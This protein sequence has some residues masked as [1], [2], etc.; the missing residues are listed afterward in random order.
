MVFLKDILPTG[1]VLLEALSNLRKFSG[2]TF[3][4]KLGGSMMADIKK[5]KSFSADV[6]LLKQC[7]IDVIVVHGAGPKLGQI[8]EKLNV[9]SSFI[10]DVRVS[11]KDDIDLVEMILSGH[12]NKQIVSEINIAG[13]MAIGFSGKDAEFMTAA[14]VR[15][16]YKETDSNIER[17]L[18]FGYVGMPKKINP[19]IFHI[20]EDSP[21]IPV[22]SPVG[23]DENGAT[24]SINAD[25]VASAVA[26]ALRANKLI[27]LTEYDG[28]KDE[29]GKLIQSLSLSE[30]E[31]LKKTKV[32]KGSLL[33]KLSACI[34][35]L[36][37]GVLQ[38]HLINMHTPHC[39]L[40]ELLTR[41][42]IG[43]LVFNHENSFAIESFEMDDRY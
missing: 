31:S 19:E 9:K 10:N 8:M 7:G 14:K 2:E 29:N 38:S 34:D 28:L 37:G 18:D 22:I 11:T 27:L 39:L 32:V 42:R 12:I 3:V 15:K 41:D 23:F 35:A 30:A 17:I 26:S 43:T 25:N 24:Y 1:K 33:P 20:F 40:L 5:I 16:T 36:K 6:V 21:A 13:G 4:I